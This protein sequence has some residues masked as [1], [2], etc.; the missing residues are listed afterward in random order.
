MKTIQRLRGRP[1]GLLLEPAGPL[2]DDLA[3]GA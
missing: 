2:V 3:G 1:D